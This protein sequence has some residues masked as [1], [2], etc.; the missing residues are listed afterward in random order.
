MGGLFLLTLTLTFDVS[1]QEQDT[2]FSSILYIEYLKLFVLCRFKEL[3]TTV[4]KSGT[5]KT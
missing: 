4:S 5:Y 3:Y 1:K 2:Y